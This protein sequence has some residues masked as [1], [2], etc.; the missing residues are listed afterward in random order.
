MCKRKLATRLNCTVRDV[1]KRN[2]CLQ[3][4][5]LR[6]HHSRGGLVITCQSRDGLD[7]ARVTFNN[8]LSTGYLTAWWLYQ[9]RLMASPSS[10]MTSFIHHLARLFW[11]ER[12]KLSSRNEKAFGVGLINLLILHSHFFGQFVYKF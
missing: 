6:H 3:Y 11:Y 12:C 10:V 5:Y 4:T 8:N 7:K 1:N 2:S 9:N